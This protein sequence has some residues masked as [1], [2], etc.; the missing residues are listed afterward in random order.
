MHP[1]DLKK[2]L[3]L[4]V[5]TGRLT[6]EKGLLKLMNSLRF[7][8]MRDIH[9]LVEAVNMASVLKGKLTIAE[10]MSAEKYYDIH[11]MYNIDIIPFGDDRY[12]ICLAITPNPPAMLYV[13]GNIN[14]LSEMPGVAIVGSRQVSRAGEEITKR[15]TSRVCEKGL[16]I[17]S[18]LAI[19]TDT[20]AH[21]A[22]LDSHAKTI[23]VLAHGLESAKPKQNTRLA[24]DILDN[25]G[26]WVSE[27]P[28]GRPAFKESFVQRNRIQ[29][30]LSATSI[31]IEAA[32]DSGT[33]T[34]A[35][36]AIKA[37]RP[38]FA[39]IPHKEN[40]PL[41]LNCEGNIQLVNNK[42]ANPLRTSEDYDKLISIIFDSINR[43]CEHSK[44][45]MSNINGAL[46]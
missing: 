20:N 21:Q 22:S 42:L 40:N 23:A 34:Q 15:V 26:A 28:V 44:I 17:V 5:Q 35:D 27:Y 25:G 41:H 31:L 14:I 36:F 2:Y 12:P 9:D 18:G 16:V 8:S 37:Q 1:T 30:G 29:V 46:L 3:G 19:G 6:S 24:K 38:I 10:F 39:V 33:M 7:D 32:K 4:T 13:R 43:I 11:Q 45:Y